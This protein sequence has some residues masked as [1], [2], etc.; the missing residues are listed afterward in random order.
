MCLVKKSRK[1]NTYSCIHTSNR[2]RFLHQMG[3]GDK[4]H[5]KYKFCKVDIL[6][7]RRRKNTKLESEFFKLTVNFS[8]VS[9]RKSLL[10]FIG[11]TASAN[12]CRA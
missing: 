6:N 9:C 5:C 12:S 8:K 7:S 1:L 3:Y 10:G 4:I 2:L 11:I